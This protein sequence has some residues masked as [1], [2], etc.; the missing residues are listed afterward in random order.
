MQ[1]HNSSKNMEKFV[2]KTEFLAKNVTNTLAL[3]MANISNF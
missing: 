2:T 3:E 1:L